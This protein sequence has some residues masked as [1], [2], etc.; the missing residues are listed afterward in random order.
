MTGARERH[1]TSCSSMSPLFLARGRYSAGWD[2]AVYF[3][4]KQ[5][6]LQCVVSTSRCRFRW[7]HISLTKNDMRNHFYIAMF[8]PI[9]VLADSGFFGMFW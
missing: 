3:W 7:L 1:S 9:T 5:Q 2:R 8:N 4:I 6:Q